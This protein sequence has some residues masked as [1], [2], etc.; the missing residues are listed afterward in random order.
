MPSGKKMHGKNTKNKSL[1]KSGLPLVRSVTAFKSYSCRVHLTHLF[2]LV[3]TWS[4]EQ[5]ELIGCATL[6]RPIT[7]RAHTQ[8]RGSQGNH[9]KHIA[10][11][12]QFDPSPLRKPL[13]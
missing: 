9:L 5:E 2:L 6:A 10:S 13:P 1:G 11:V 7:A 8:T 12:F 3:L 4:K